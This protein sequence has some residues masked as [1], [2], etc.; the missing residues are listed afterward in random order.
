[1]A[2]DKNMEK[3]KFDVRLREWNLRNGVL[4]EEDLKAHLKDLEDVSKN[5]VT[6]EIDETGLNGSSH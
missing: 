3:L 5:A 1:M 2:L 4:K 6:I